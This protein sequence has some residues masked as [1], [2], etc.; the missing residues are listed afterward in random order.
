[1]ICFV[2][3]E[4]EQRTSYIPRLRHWGTITDGTLAKNGHGGGLYPNHP[5]MVKW[6][7]KKVSF[8][9]PQI[10]RVSQ[11]GH[12]HA[13]FRDRVGGAFERPFPV[14]DAGKR[15]PEIVGIR[16][17]IANNDNPDSATYASRL[18]RCIDPGE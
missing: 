7:G 16:S 10:N 14:I 9:A 17:M 3:G 11:I 1:M 18:P 12:A 4:G 13:S 5:I 8:N 6:I 2:S 15:Y